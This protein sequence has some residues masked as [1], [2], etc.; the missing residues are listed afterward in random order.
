MQGIASE[1]A[2]YLEKSWMLLHSSRIEPERRVARPKGF[3]EGDRI[4]PTTCCTWLTQISILGISGRQGHRA[5]GG[6]RWD[7]TEA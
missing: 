1:S 6:Q 4:V 5:G 7:S 2:Q 3:V